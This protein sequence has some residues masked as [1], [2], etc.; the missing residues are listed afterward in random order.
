MTANE[1]SSSARLRELCSQRL[2]KR[3]LIVASN[4][5][6][7]EYHLTEDGQ[8]QAQRGSGGVVTALNT[9]SEY[10]EVEWIASAMGEGDRRA[11]Q[12]AQ[13]QRIKA[14]PE[15]NL[16]LHFVITPRNNYHKYYNVFCNP[17]LWF[18]QHYMWNLPRTPNIDR[19][20]YDAWENG[21]VAVNQAFAQAVLEEASGDETSPLILLNDYHLYLA[22]G[23]IRAQRPDLIIHHFTHIPW[24]APCYWQLL[25]ACMRQPIHRS[26][27][28]VDIVGLQTTR[29]V[30]NFLQCCASFIDEAEVDYRQQTVQMNEHMVRVKAYPVSVDVAGLQRLV[31][32]PA[33]RE[34]EAKLR[35]LCGEQTIVRVDRAE[36]SKN[37]IRGFDVLLERYPQ[38]RGRVKFIA[39]LVPTRTHLRQYQRYMEELTQLIEAINSKYASDDW[40]PI[41]YFYE[42]NYVQAIA[43]MRMYDVLLVNAV[44]DGMNLVA[45]EGPTVNDRDGVLILSETVGAHEQLGEDC[46]AVAPADIEGTVQALYTAL[47]M[48]AGERHRHAVALKRSIEKEDVTDWLWHLLNDVA[49]LTRPLS[50]LSGPESAPHPGPRSR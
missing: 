32:S 2:A 9:L 25:P 24:P 36:P 48:P 46:L 13:N 37:I 11:V 16:Y 10:V 39:F 26:L 47:V 14:S 22:G 29:D 7:I 41:D 20:V 4:R 33:L 42:N 15:G 17:L 8:L 31:S 21:Y 49:S 40:K 3:R 38:F 1:D 44:V 12:R 28:A 34:Y 30:R 35:P 45:K 43:G 18:L 19:G 23:Y 5:G 50:A 27:C 6:S